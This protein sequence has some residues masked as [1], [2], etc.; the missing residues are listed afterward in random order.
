MTNFNKGRY[1]NTPM[2][3]LLESSW[4]QFIFVLG[5]ALLALWKSEDSALD[6]TLLINKAIICSI[7]IQEECDNYMTDVGVVLGVKIA[8]S[9]GKMQITHVGIVESK[10]FDLS[11]SAVDDVNAA[12]KWAEPGS[13]ILSRLAFLNCDQSLFLF[14]IM[15]DGIHYRVSYLCMMIQFKIWVVSYISIRVILTIECYELTKAY[16][17]VGLISSMHE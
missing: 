15:E 5:D 9:V 11:G 3:G 1:S 4:S 16:S 2:K 17:P 14:E 7:D 13:I 8:L 6:M 10:H 12:E